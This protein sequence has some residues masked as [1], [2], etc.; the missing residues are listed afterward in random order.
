MASPKVLKRRLT[1]TDRSRV[2]VIRRVPDTGWGLKWIV[3]IEAGGFYQ[4]FYGTWNCISK[5]PTQNN[6]HQL[7]LTILLE[8][9]YCPKILLHTA[10]SQNPTTLTNSY[11]T[12]CVAKHGILGHEYTEKLTPSGDK[13][14]TGS[15]PLEPRWG[16]PPYLLPRLPPP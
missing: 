9:L 4:R 16:S 5:V 3:P 15:L 8:T 13:A 14:P 1:C 2:P 12:L 11:N 6:F 7:R 10:I